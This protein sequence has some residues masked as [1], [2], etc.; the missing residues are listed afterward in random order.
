MPKGKDSK[1]VV[2]YR[3]DEAERLNNPPVGLAVHDTAR[4]AKR[5]YAYDPHTP[6]TLIWAGKAERDS[7]EVEAPSIHVHERLSTAAIMAAVQKETG[8]LDF[9][10]DEELDRTKAIEFYRHPMDW[11]N[12]LILGDSLVVMTSLLEKERLAGKVQMIYIDPPYG[13]NYNSN[14]QA[15]LGNRTPKESADD[16]VTREAEQIQ[17]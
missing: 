17:A 3:H 16:T 12:R 5:R 4:P 14:F 9:F 1:R 8:Q 6:P 15:R 11:A 10:A 2:D 13:I 7:L